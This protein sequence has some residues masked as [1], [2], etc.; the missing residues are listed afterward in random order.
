MIIAKEGDKV[1]TG[2]GC[3]CMGGR[4]GVVRVGADRSG[5]GERRLEEVDDD[6]STSPSKS[7][8]FRPPIL[9]PGWPPSLV[10][11][12]A[13]RLAADTLFELLHLDQG[14][15]GGWAATGGGTAAAAMTDARGGG[16]R[17]EDI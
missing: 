10:L 11:G 1:W 9:S 2:P 17:R 15:G 12:A 5:K 3:G 7:F 13:G 4:T 6:I 16:G 8:R 14:G